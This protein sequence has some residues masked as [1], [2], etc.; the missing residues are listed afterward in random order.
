MPCSFL[1]LFYSLPSGLL[2]HGEKMVAVAPNAM[3]SDNIA[4]KSGRKELAVSLCIG[5]AKKSI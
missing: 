2:P 3:F 5:V 4:F 1:L